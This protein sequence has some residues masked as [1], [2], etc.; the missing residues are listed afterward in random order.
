MNA[1]EN[2]REHATTV[3]FEKN[4]LT[5]KLQFSP[6][7]LIWSLIKIYGNAF[8]GEGE[9][10]GRHVYSTDLYCR[11]GHIRHRDKLRLAASRLS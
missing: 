11:R 1:Y 10:G 9:R 5:S 4:I 8:L 2:E 6:L 7:E 3:T